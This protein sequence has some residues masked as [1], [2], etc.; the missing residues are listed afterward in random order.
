MERTMIFH[1]AP[2]KL[3]QNV[4]LMLTFQPPTNKQL[5]TTQNLVAWKVIPMHA[6]PGS[7]AMNTASVTYTGRLAFGSSQDDVGNVIL[8]AS[9]VEMKVG[10][11]IELEWDNG[12]AV[13][14]IPSKDAS[15]GKIIKAK[16]D[17]PYKQNISVGT[18]Q[19][20]G[21]FDVY[22]PSFLWKVGST[23]YAE[24]DFHPT[25]KSY[26]N[27]GYVQNEFITAD[28][29]SDLLQQWN[30]TEL[31]PITNWTFTEAANG[32]FSITPMNSL[33]M[34]KASSFAPAAPQEPDI[35]VASTL[36]W[37]ESVPRQVVSG[38]FA[39]ISSTL[40]AKGVTYH[41]EHYVRQGPPPQMHRQPEGS[42][43]RGAL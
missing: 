5:S 8:G 17:T 3:T 15:L 39:D 13:W 36:N 31:E 29:A 41:E 9:T 43:L 16:N 12:S 20:T 11:Y 30:L 35:N 25:L 28:I 2:G 27:L 23:L 38:V 1:Y 18:L 6:Q 40:A 22:S 19:K 24:G 21:G 33:A 42:D 37:D 4:N 26:V 7:G 32:S 14:G 34:F 10:D